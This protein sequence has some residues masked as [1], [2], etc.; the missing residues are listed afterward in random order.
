MSVYVARKIAVIHNTN[1]NQV[2][3][4]NEECLYCVSRSGVAFEAALGVR[5]NVCAMCA[6]QRVLTAHYT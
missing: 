4:K 1:P 6:R 2:F 3:N 5:V